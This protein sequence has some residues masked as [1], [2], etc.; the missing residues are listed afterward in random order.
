MSYLQPVTTSLAWL[1][2]TLGCIQHLHHETLT[3]SL[4]TSFEQF[5]DFIENIGVAVLG[6][7]ELTFNRLEALMHQLPAFP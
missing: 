1:V 6:K 4:D 3:R 2:A 5:L 7:L